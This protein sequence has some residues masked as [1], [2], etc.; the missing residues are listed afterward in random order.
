MKLS[1]LPILFLLS[2][3]TAQAEE[4]PRSGPEDS[5]IRF[6]TFDQNQVFRIDAS[7]GAS[8]MIV[9]ADDEKIETIGAGVAFKDRCGSNSGAGNP[10]RIG[11]KRRIAEQMV[12]RRLRGRETNG[13]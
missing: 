9:F 1:A 2:S 12:R 4:A 11:K 3:C 5:R 6:V 13:N 10:V 8:T 7:Y